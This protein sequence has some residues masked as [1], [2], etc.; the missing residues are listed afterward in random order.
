VFL[1]QVSLPQI[2]IIETMFFPQ[3]LFAVWYRLNSVFPES[4]LNRKIN[5]C[6]QNYFPEKSA[7]CEIDSNVRF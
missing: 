6:K 1:P 2:R 7:N 3:I 4:F 5:S